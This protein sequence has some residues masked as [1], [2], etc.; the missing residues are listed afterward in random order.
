MSIKAVTIRNSLLTILTAGSLISYSGAA[1]APP[2]AT[3][4]TVSDIMASIVMPAA[5]VLWE[6]VLP[7]SDADGNDILVGPDSDE[8]WIKVR[9]AAISL[10]ASTNLLMVPGL[11]VK[12]PA[13]ETPQGELPPEAIRELINTQSA[14]W[15]AWNTAMHNTAMALLNAIDKR[16]TQAI[17]DM[18]A[19]LD[20]P[21][22]S[23]HEQFWYPNQ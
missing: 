7:D 21:C 6:A 10:A 19:T 8:G 11:Q 2:F 23:C 1:D 22:T 18:T 17:W 9:E 16:D 13:L 5:N 15:Y 14:A 4:L 3:D 20:A 12:D